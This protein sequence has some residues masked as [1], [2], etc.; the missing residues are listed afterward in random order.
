MQATSPIWKWLWKEGGKNLPPSE[1]EGEI[2]SFDNPG[3]TYPKDITIAIE[4]V[5]SGSGDP[6]PENVRPISGWTG[7]NVTRTGKNLLNADEY[8]GNYKLSNGTYSFSPYVSGTIRIPLSALVGKTV[9]FSF[10]VTVSTHTSNIHAQGNINGVTVRG[11]SISGGAS[12]Q[13]KITV[14]PATDSDYVVISCGSGSTYN[15][16]FSK[17]Q[18]ELGSTASTYEPYTGTTYPVSWQSEAGTVY[19][20]TLDVTTG[21]L[22]VTMASCIVDGT[23]GLVDN[24]ALTYGGKQIRFTPSIEKAYGF[25]ESYSGIKCNLFKAESSAEPLVANGRITNGNIYFNMPADVTTVEL[26]NT[27]FKNN[28]TQVVYELATPQTYQLTPTEVTLPLGENNV[29]ADTGDI[30]VGY[31][32]EDSLGTGEAIADAMKNADASHGEMVKVAL[33]K[34]F[35]DAIEVTTPTFSTLPKTFSAVGITPDHELVQDGVAYLSN[36]NALGSDWTISTG[37]DEFTISGTC[38]DSTYVKASFCIK[39]KTTATV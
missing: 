29:W 10:N 22:T 26:A 27:W 19:G 39:Q 11:T 25:P 18:L 6:S 35:N 12:G 30:T 21:L 14:I 23:Q 38:N 15:S 34:T 7:A 37:N 1:Y 28:V 24:G 2:V 4:P 32:R 9:T 33:T 17:F 5:Q 3:Y 31:L 13:A 16:T 8:Y 20:G 36:P